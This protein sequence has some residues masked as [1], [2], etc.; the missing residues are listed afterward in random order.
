M[1]EAELLATFKG[2]KLRDMAFSALSHC[3]YRYEGLYPEPLQDN[4]IKV[5]AALD[6]GD[7]G[8]VALLA[9]GGPA[10][11]GWHRDMNPGGAVISPLQRGS[12]RETKFLCCKNRG[13]QKNMRKSL[14]TPMME[15]LRRIKHIQ[16][17][18]QEPGDVV[19]LSPMTA[20]AVLTGSGA[21]SLLTT[22][23]EV[24]EEVSRRVQ[25]VGKYYQPKGSRKEILN[26]GSMERS[27][28]KR[29]KRF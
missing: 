18:I 20:H 16:Y 22:T 4:Y 27:R 26:P 23:F 2:T 13:R 19:I 24:T 9:N 7:I 25:R 14:P 15:D 8:H 11:T 17:C 28:G 1:T 3:P 12:N 5:N 29:V 10:W 21:N 6:C